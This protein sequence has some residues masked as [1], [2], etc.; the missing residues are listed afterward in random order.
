MHYRFFKDEIFGTS[1]YCYELKQTNI[2]D[3]GED[4]ETEERRIRRTNEEINS[5]E[6]SSTSACFKSRCDEISHSI[7]ITISGIEKKCSFDFEQ[8]QF[9]LQ[10]INDSGND[11]DVALWNVTCPRL[12]SVCPQ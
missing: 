5:N 7:F 10:I 9:K 11:D 6:E 3:N 1:S 4:L 12:S 2:E 8:L